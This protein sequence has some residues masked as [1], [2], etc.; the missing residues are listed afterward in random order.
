MNCGHAL[1]AARPCI[2]IG[3]RIDGRARRILEFSAAR[4][5]NEIH[6]CGREGDAHGGR[7]LE[8]VAALDTLF[9]QETAA[10]DE[11][12]P[13]RG[14]HG[15]KRFERQTQAVLERPAAIVRA[16]I[17]ARKERGHR[18]GVGVVNF[19]AVETGGLRALGGGGEQRR[20]RFR[21]VT[22]MRQFDVNDAL[23]IAL[24]E[25]FELARG[26]RLSPTA[27]AERKQTRP[28]LGFARALASER[29][30]VLI[31]HL[32]EALEKPRGF[33]TATHREEI[34]D[35]NEKPCPAAARC[36]TASTSRRSPPI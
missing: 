12:L 11:V 4:S 3:G 10:D 31:G 1:V 20:Q 18:I 19:D 5:R 29:T 9:R 8:P 17:R 34:D 2:G 26:Q 33:R 14:A 32:Q 28:H 25:R 36:L 7:F 24:H 15:L 30:T 6:P 27:F 13:D 23:A 21:Q 35:L 22:N 16:R